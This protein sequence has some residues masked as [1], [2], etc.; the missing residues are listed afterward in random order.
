MTQLTYYNRPRFGFPGMPY[1][2]GGQGLTKVNNT[3]V[4]QV[5]RGVMVPTVLGEEYGV[6][7]EGVSVTIASTNV[8]ADDAALLA[9]KINATPSLAGVVEKAETTGSTLFVTYFDYLPHTV[10]VSVPSANNDVTPIIIAVIANAGQ[11]FRAGIGVI[12]DT[13]DSSGESVI[14]PPGPFAEALFQGIV[15]FDHTVP[16]HTLPGQEA[17]PA[18]WPL[19][20]ISKGFY[21]VVINQDVAIGDPVY[22]QMLPNGTHL[23]GEF[24]MDA[25]LGNAQQ[26]T[27]GA[28]WHRAGTAASGKAVLELNLIG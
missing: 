14:I 22:F 11:N 26:L 19:T 16:N 10:M 25:D 18:N 3:R 1:R 13:N 12:S 9:A 23:P 28:A 7:I 15:S 17:I 4:H 24:R 2:P 5:D 8:A 20:V 6:S 21:W 27:K